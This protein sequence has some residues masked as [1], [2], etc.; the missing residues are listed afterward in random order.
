MRRVLLVCAAITFAIA[1]TDNITEPIPDRPSGAPGTTSVP[2]TVAFATTTT[3]DGL[4]ISTDKDDYQPGDVVHFTG[5]GWQP[6]DV[7]DIV[8]TDDPQT[9]EPHRWAVSVGQ[10]GTFQDATYVVDQGDL[11]VT[12]TLVATSR[13]TGQSLTVIFTDG[14]L[15]I[16]SG[17]NA[18]SPNPFSP[19]ADLIKD[20]VSIQVRNAGSGS[21]TNIFVSIRSGTGAV[22][23]SAVLVREFTVGTLA[24]N[25]DAAVLWDG[26]NTGGAIVDDGAY[27][28]RIFSTTVAENQPENETQAR[29][30]TIIV[31]NANPEAAVNAISDGTKDVAMLITGTASDLPANAGLQKVDVT[32]RRASDNVVLATGAATST[33]TNFSTWSFS[34]T[35]TEASAQK[36]SATA[37]DNA[38][39]IGSSADRAFTVKLP[40]VAK[41][42][43]AFTNLSSPTITFGATSTVLSGEIKAG[44]L[45]PGG[46]VSITLNGVTQQAAIAA[47]GKFSSSFA[48]G[49]LGVAGSP[50]S[51][52]YSFAEN[53]TFNAASGTGSLTVE[54][55]APTF[56]NLSAPAITFGDTP[57]SISGEIAAG[58]LIPTG[59]V[60]ITL[61]GVTQAAVI[62]LDGK[63]TSSFGTG[64]LGVAG[65]PYDITY[66]YAG[67][68]NF[69]TIGSTI[70]TLTVNKATPAFSDLTSP[71]IT[72]G[73][74]PTI[75]GKIS[76]G[77]LIP[78]G[79]VAVT[80]N[81]TTQQAAIQNDGT[82]SSSFTG[83]LGVT[84]S[85]YS[86]SYT[87]AGSANFNPAPDGSTSL[88]VNRKPLTIEADDQEKFYN[89]QA[90]TGFTVQYSGFIPGETESA[91]G[92]TLSFSGD[93]VTAVDAG[94]YTITPE[95]L[96]SD[97]YE[98][99]F[100]D[101]ILT[102]KKVVLTV[103]AVNRVKVWDGSPYPFNTNPAA[104]TDVTY[105]GFVNQE[106]PSVL[107]GTLVFGAG[108]Q[109]ATGT[110]TNIPSGL[111]A[112][113][114]TFTYVAGTLVIQSWKLTGFYAPVDMTIGSLMWNTVKGGSTVPLKFNV[115]QSAVVDPTKE[116]TDVGAIQQPFT[117]T[118]VT[119]SGGTADQIEFTTTGGT[120]L[121]Y[122][123][124]DHQFIQNWQT[125]RSPGACYRA[126][127]TTL[128]GSTIQALFKLK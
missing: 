84:N 97:N 56:S 48:T 8:L 39:N 34:Y 68:G 29:K 28:A 128:D 15:Q 50:Y 26:K 74:T 80:L 10:D 7:L 114:Y 42:T 76:K 38:G 115:Y 85:P 109:T 127:M 11:D 111:G 33:G 116:R 79:N 95:G 49:L 20:Q 21:V 9:H 1:C 121:R 31:D 63:F 40:V 62:G 103:T 46:D 6:G 69:N 61:N 45:I 17:G 64:S 24:G 4:S 99:E 27:T 43:P 2:G 53:A 89:G 13:A 100:K 65:S 3:E 113:N 37:T 25:A 94:S 124:E 88:T 86:V 101:G 82:F 71:A 52:A 72:Y 117:V 92:G 83:L 22:G 30:A 14:N 126:T 18:P 57:T 36:A 93:A 96:T 81:G 19:N 120:S 104:T 67:D 73:Q 59:S 75:S 112:T 118:P 102:I 87:Y 55:A 70:R 12:F 110:H 78:P 51:I 23:P 60:S 90:F 32:I 107:T 122:S 16:R 108:A 35:P 91:L 105:S 41:V 77:S 66:S 58:S 54:K 125:P 44:S 98:I 5:Y 106:G 119:C 47:D 123:I